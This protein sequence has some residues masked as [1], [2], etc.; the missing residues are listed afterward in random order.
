MRRLSFVMAGVAA[1]TMALSGCTQFRTAVG[2]QKDVPNEFDVVNNAPLAIPPDFNLRPPRPGA[3]PS[4]RVSTTAQ[5]RETIFRA[6]GGT[7]QTQVGDAQMSPGERTLI[8]AA[9]A[10]KT[11]D[12]IRQVINQEAASE[13]P[14]DRSF[15]DRLI[16]WREAKNA[17]KGVL[18]PVKEESRLQEQK[19]A[20]ATVSTQFSSPPTVERKS[21]S[22]GGFFG[23]LF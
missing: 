21:T 16:F 17:N 19:G 14:F 3:A 20:E 8:T 11:P 12:N 1:L 5:A 6:G 13:H 15:V 23:S 4:Q 22:G 7:G 2:L 10:E 18:D 9:G